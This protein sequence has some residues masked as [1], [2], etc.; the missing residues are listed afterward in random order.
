MAYQGIVGTP[1]KFADQT[2]LPPKESVDVS[3][4]FLPSDKGPPSGPSRLQSLPSS[5]QSIR[6]RVSLAGVSGS[7]TEPSTEPPWEPPPCEDFTLDGRLIITY[8]N[9]DLQTLPLEGSVI[10]P[11]LEL[12]RPAT[13]MPWAS[14]EGGGRNVISYGR[15]H[16]GAPKPVE[17]MLSNPTLVDATWTVTAAGVR[18]KASV[19]QQQQADGSRVHEAEDEAR[20]GPFIVKP[21]GG[22]LPGR[23]LRLPRTQVITITFAPTDAVEYTQNLVFAVSKGRVCT[24]ALEGTGSFDETEEHQ[25]LLKA[26][27]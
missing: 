7:H 13:G 25:A 11:S 18:P 2:Y 10:H 6:R 16:V 23:G 5:S 8:A 24:L 3:L 14:A 4:H 12:R 20:F 19:G 9:G 26:K 17:I 27:I 15:V 1:A 22:L 21:A